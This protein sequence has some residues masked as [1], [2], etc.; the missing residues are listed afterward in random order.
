MLVILLGAIGGMM[1]SGIIGLFIGPVV[2]S[3]SYKIFC[4]WIQND[5][6]QLQKPEPVSP[7]PKNPTPD[8]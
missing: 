6:S 4:S 2:L 8:T 1:M 5:P 3:I 7:E